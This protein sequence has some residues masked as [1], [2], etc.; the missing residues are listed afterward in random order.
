MI[1]ISTL[2]ILFASILFS[3][4][5][6]S[7][8][9][10]VN[11]GNSATYILFSGDSLHIASGTY[12]G[13]IL[14]WQEGAKIS[15]A[16]GANFKPILSYYLGRIYVYGSATLSSINGQSS[17]FYLKN[18]GNI[19]VTG[20]TYL[21]NSAKLENNYGATITF[22][23]GVNFNNST[24]INNGT[25]LAKDD[26]YS[27]SSSVLTNNNLFTV[28][29]NLQV[30]GSVSTNG[31]TFYT[32]KKLTLSNATFTNTC[33]T[34]ADATIEINNSTVNNDGLFW[35]SNAT[36]N[37]LITNGGTIVSTINGRIK[38]VNF[39]NNG[40]I[41]GR[42]FLYFTGTTTNN[43][44]GKIGKSGTTSDTLKIYDVTRTN[45]NGIFD[46]QWGTIY[47]NTK[48]VAFTAPDTVYAYPSCAMQYISM[49]TVL[50]VKWNFFTVNLSNNIPSISWSSEQEEGTY[51]EIQRSYNGTDFSSV[52][53]TASETGKT[54]YSYDDRNVNTDAAI[55]YYRIKAIERS[56][57]QKFTEVKTIR[58]N[59]K[60]GVSVQ[61]APNPFTS[62]FSINYQS[63]EKG[64]L[65]IKIYSLN[66]QLQATKASSVSKGFN[67]VAVT[68]AA[69][70]VKGIYVV[71]L[72]SNGKMVASE[73]IVK[74]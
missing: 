70:L 72:S 19:T 43:G 7:Q 20:D 59:N 2:S 27:G 54:N 32:K 73:K 47:P 21:G 67:S 33:R 44:G 53:V 39:V 13:I 11:N 17:S 34:A 9:T 8:T 24:L 22:N 14:N 28:E 3:T 5:I 29:G 38:S 58:F 18:Y 71:Q 35:A 1:R 49:M 40:T 23:G 48:Y 50:P 55:V 60:Q 30:N 15:V 68:E 62:Q 65:V 45:N 6:N 61:T 31:G 12:T 42:G 64:M 25:I 66:G 69:S 57:A 52:T 4:S 41:S 26:W 36:H 74:Q 37:S 51:F 46:N 10:Y 56:G 16:D 63:E